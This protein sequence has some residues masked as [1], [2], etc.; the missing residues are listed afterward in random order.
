M[1]K[2][3][4]TNLPKNSLGWVIDGRSMYW[5]VRFLYERYGV[6]IMITENGMSNLDTVHEDG[7]VCD[8]IR[9]NYMDEYLHNL[10]R[11]I[12]EDIPVLGYQ[13]WSLMDS[14]EWAEGY[15][16][17]FGLV[18]VDFKI[19]NPTI[20]KSGYHYK[21]IIESNGTTL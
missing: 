10:K 3:Y 21:Q 16:P 17:R 15:A 4:T 1:E 7:E 2:E 8:D 11:A 9:I 5:T 18:Y 6:P 20:K 12:V 14:F 19:G 13:H